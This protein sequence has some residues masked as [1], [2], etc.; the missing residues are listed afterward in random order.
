MFK[1]TWFKSW[2]KTGK[3][4]YNDRPNGS[5]SGIFRIGLSVVIVEFLSLIRFFI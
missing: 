2:D 4:G 5:V 3:S 1:E